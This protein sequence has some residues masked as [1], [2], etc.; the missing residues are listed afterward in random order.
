MSPSTRN[1]L[2]LSLA[3]VGSA[4]AADISFSS[5]PFAGSNANPNDGVRTV[6]AGNQT[7]LPSFDQ[8]L[9]RF[10][11]G[12]SFFSFGNTLNVVNSLAA[13]LSASGVNLIVIQDT[14]VGFNAGSAANLIAD[15]IHQDGAGFFAYHNRGLGVNR[16][17][18]ST[19]LNLNTADLSVLARI[20][21]PSGSAAL[22]ALPGFSAGN[23]AVAVVPEPSSWALLGAG[24]AVL[25]AALRREAR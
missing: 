1:L 12:A 15:A 8:G 3:V 4:H 2:A 9:D 19:N 10:V 24:L 13:N 14:A 23:F 22:A 21:S 5:N 11:F 25:A 17:V 20:E 18:Y 7:S 16:L 6:F